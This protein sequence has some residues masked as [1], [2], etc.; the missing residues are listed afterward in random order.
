MVWSDNSGQEVDHMQKIWTDWWGTTMGPGHKS[1]AGSHCQLSSCAGDCPWTKK[2]KKRGQGSGNMW[3]LRRPEKVLSLNY[4]SWVFSSQAENKGLRQLTP[5]TGAS[6]EQA[7]PLPLTLDPR[8]YGHLAALPGPPA[9]NREAKLHV[10][11]ELL[12]LAN[13]SYH[14]TPSANRTSYQHILHF[15]SL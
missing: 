9:D 4:F 14:R 5:Q 8:V 11:L 2:K 1:W 15:I 13:G 3:T 12:S 6:A 7:E 10:H